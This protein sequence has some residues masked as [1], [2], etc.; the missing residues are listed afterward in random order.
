MT[1]AALGFLA[2]QIVAPPG[3]ADG[4]GASLSSGPTPVTS[5]VSVH[6]D[7]RSARSDPHWTALDGRERMWVVGTLAGLS[8]EEKVAQLVVPYLDG[9]EPRAGSARWERARRLVREHRVGGFI[10]GV[11]SSY[12]TASWLNQLQSWSDVPLL[13]SADLEWGP[14]TRLRGATVLPMN[15]ALSASGPASVAREAGR[16]TA[17]ESRAAGI[18]M[19]FAPVADVNVNPENPVINTRS[20]GSDPVQVSDRVVAF[21]EGARSAGLLTVVKHFPGHGDTET[22]SH[23]EMPVL[24]VD[25]WRLEDVELRPFRA[26]IRAGVDGVMTA[27]LAVPALDP[28]S[29][30]RPA[31]LSPPILTDLLRDQLGFGGL[32]ITDALHMDGVKE[33]GDPGTVAVEA[34]LAGA[35]ILLIPPDEATAIEAVVDAVRR[36]EIDEDR[37]DRSVRRVLAAKAVAG[38]DGGRAVNLGQLLG[39]VGRGDHEAW[40]RQVAERSIT[41]VRGE[42]GVL[43]VE[44]RDRSVLAVIYDDRRRHDSGARFESA[45]A[46]HGARVMSVRLSRRSEQARLDRV[47][48]VAGEADVVV[49]ASFSRATP[50][51]G[52]LGLPEPIA[53]LAA[54]LAADGAPVLSFGDP[55]LLGQMPSVATYLLA[56]SRADVSQDAAVRAL[57]GEIPITG[58][59]PIDLPPGYGVGHGVT[60]PALPGVTTPRR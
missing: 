6:V 58:R 1:T 24:G 4:T 44:V 37:L 23:L 11:G 36:G 50:W 34:V 48:E 33:R 39:Q 53:A 5:V 43:P 26:A 2:L 57:V 60:V 20:Y 56:W 40:G 17:L 35:D 59:L 9:G 21:I 51:K 3:G 27:H 18:H 42:P 32:V 25:R 41:L 15:M 7:A 30:L 49:F 45:L 29:G 46:E 14:G 47:R 52:T 12:G 28:G 22:D 31:T 10:V 16:I 38:L 55:Y 13:I 8:L 19:A 54:D